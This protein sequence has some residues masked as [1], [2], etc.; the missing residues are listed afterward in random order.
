[1]HGLF[2]ELVDEYAITREENVVGLLGVNKCCNWNSKLSIWNP[3]RDEIE[4]S[5]YN[6]ALNTLYDWGTRSL[7]LVKSR[8]ILRP[9][10]RPIRSKS[11]VV[12]EDARSTKC[13]SH[14]WL[15]DPPYADA[16]NYH[17]LGDFFLAWY[18][19][20]LARAFPEWTPDARA[21]LAVRGDGDD[22]R[23]SMVEIYK[24]LARHMPD[25]PPW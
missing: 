20:Q 2:M 3:W 8:W 19:R 21:E 4:Q 23:Q 14:L 10:N 6:Q 25:T 1:M 24:N 11:C 13:R 16:I 9:R 22:F 5:Y 17:E 18:D 15:T 12:A 7:L